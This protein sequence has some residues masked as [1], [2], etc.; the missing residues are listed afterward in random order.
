VSHAIC[1]RKRSPPR[2]TNTKNSTLLKNLWQALHADVRRKAL[3]TLGRVVTQQ[4]KPLRGE[5][6]KREE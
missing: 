5:E 3:Q 1:L 4:I 6:V 2:P